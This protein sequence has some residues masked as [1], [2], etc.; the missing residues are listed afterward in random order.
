[1]RYLVVLIIVAGFT[2]LPGAASS[3][4]LGDDG[5]RRGQ[6]TRAIVDHVADGDT[7]SVQGSQGSIQVRLIGLDT[8]ETVQPGAPVECGGPAAS[9][10]MH[11]M[12]KPGDRVKLIT[13]PTQGRRD[14]Y[15]RLLRYVK[16]GHKDV[17]KAQIRLGHANVYVFDDPFKRLDLYN[18][19]EQHARDVNAGVWRECGG[20]FHHPL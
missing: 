7:I 11:R 20:D 10:A 17:G 2:A 3:P 4:A 12:L 8:P 19:A 16:R 1:M 18:R 6:V 9:A 13:D 14:Q 5:S 15:G